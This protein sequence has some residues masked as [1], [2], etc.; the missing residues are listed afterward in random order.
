M[1]HT[2]ILPRG[3]AIVGLVTSTIQVPPAF[4]LRPVTSS[5]PEVWV[6]EW[7][8]QTQEK[9]PSKTAPTDSWY[10]KEE[11]VP[12]TL[13]SAEFVTSEEGALDWVDRL[14]R[15]NKLSDELLEYR[16]RQLTRKSF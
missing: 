1:F 11:A 4:T 16:A 9:P 5:P 2:N 12:W 3:H 6:V 8:P 7:R 14:T 15:A 10:D 13:F